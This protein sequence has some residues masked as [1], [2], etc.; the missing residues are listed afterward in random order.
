[1]LLTSFVYIQGYT[2]ILNKEMPQVAK[3][4]IDVTTLYVDDM[5]ITMMI[6]MVLNS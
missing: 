4:K 6:Y 5:I 1:M 3:T 2:L